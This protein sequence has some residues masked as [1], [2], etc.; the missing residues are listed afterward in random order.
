[1]VLPERGRPEMKWNFRDDLATWSA[2]GMSAMVPAP[3][4]GVGAVEAGVGLS[5]ATGTLWVGA[6]QPLTSMI[7]RLARESPAGATDVPTP[8]MAKCAV[9]V[10]D[11]P[12]HRVTSLSLHK[13]GSTS[14]PPVDRLIDTCWNSATDFEDGG[15]DSVTVTTSSAPS[16]RIVARTSLVAVGKD[17]NGVRSAYRDTGVRY[18]FE[19]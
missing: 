6:F 2:A 16:P 8:A 4:Y 7:E 3:T 18:H 13:I 14:S 9:K 15:T 12:G 10:S 17:C 5:M 11:S 1:R 19:C